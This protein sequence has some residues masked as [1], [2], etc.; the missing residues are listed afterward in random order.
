MIAYPRFMT[1]KSLLCNLEFYIL[2]IW[3]LIKTKVTNGKWKQGFAL[4]FLHSFSAS[5]LHSSIMRDHLYWGCEFDCM[6]LKCDIYWIWRINLMIF[7]LFRS[8]LT[9]FTYYVFLAHSSYNYDVNSHHIHACLLFI[10]GSN[11]TCS[12]EIL[13]ILIHN[14]LNLLWGHFRFQIGN[15]L[16]C[17]LILHANMKRTVPLNL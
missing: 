8:T 3:N 11:M 17:Q 9:G 6:L 13:I 12:T 4:H 7:C 16:N 5:L 1:S 2:F 14:K 15:I 10:L